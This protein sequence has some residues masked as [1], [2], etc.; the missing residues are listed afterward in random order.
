M[1]AHAQQRVRLAEN[2]LSSEFTRFFIAHRDDLAANPPQSAAITVD[3]PREGTL[4]PSDIIPP[5]FQ[6]RDLSPGV[7]V[8]RAE[9]TFRSHGPKIRLWS[10]G[11]KMQ[12]GPLDDALTGYVSP[13]RRKR[14]DAYHR[15][16]QRRLF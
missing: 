14:A 2:P 3:Y 5:L 4:F 15:Q 7:A 16:A 13:R 1:A 10:D 12:I 6:W 9:V 11:A 8:W